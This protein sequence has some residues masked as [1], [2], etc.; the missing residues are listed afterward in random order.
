M[1][2]LELSKF[3]MANDKK[4]TVNESIEIIF[5]NYKSR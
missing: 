3:L 2:Y 4:A 1:N 5:I